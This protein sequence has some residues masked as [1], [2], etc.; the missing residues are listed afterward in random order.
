MN[1]KSS[2]PTAQ[3]AV[4]PRELQQGLSAIWLKS[5]LPCMISLRVRLA[6]LFETKAPGDRMTQT[7]FQA[8]RL[9][10]KNPPTPQIPQ[11]SQPRPQSLKLPAVAGTK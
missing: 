6:L 8:P 9:L 5:I 2:T 4:F 11:K 3:A 7:L 1:C 10:L